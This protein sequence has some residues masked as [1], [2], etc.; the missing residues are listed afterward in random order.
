M[1]AVGETHLWKNQFQSEAISEE[2]TLEMETYRWRRS[3]LRIIQERVSQAGKTAKTKA[4][5]PA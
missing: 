1:V 3:Q 5:G 4:L 2:V